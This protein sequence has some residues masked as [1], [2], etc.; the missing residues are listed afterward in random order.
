MDRPDKTYHRI[1]F[2]PGDLNGITVTK[3]VSNANLDL[4]RHLNLQIYPESFPYNT[5]YFLEKGIKELGDE[6]LNELKKFDAIFLGA[7]G[8]DTRIARGTMEKGILLKIRKEFNQVVNLRPVV[9]FDGVCSRIVDKGSRDIDMVICRENTEGLYCGGGRIENAGTDDEVG[10]QEMR[11]SYRVVKRLTEYAIEVAKSRK[12][13]PTP[14]VHMIFKSNVLEHAGKIWD[15][16]YNE[17][18]QREDVDIRYMHFDIFL[19]NMV[20]HPEYFDVVVTENLMGDGATDLGAILQGGIG[21]AVSGNINIDGKFPSMFEPIHG[22]A[23]DKWYGLDERG[24]PLPGTFDAGKVQ[25]IRP[26]AALFSYAMLLEHIGEVKAGGV[27]KRAA[28]TN[29]RHSE[30][31]FMPLDELVERACKYVRDA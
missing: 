7:V 25:L 22:T 14:R 31:K 6:E 23:P 13:F 15:R 18:R 17:F 30:Y 3:A 19:A 11:C 26:E 9:L 29:L 28:L 10:I 21:M 27:L 5:D 8:D 20:D 16:V 1:A 2:I 24:N 12:R 4:E